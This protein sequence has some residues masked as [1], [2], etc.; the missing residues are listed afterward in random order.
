MKKR[1]SPLVIV[2]L[3]LDILVAL[4]IVGMLLYGFLR[5][6]QRE[7]QVIEIPPEVT[8]PVETP[9]PTP[10]P[11]PVPV[12][13][14]APQPID[15]YRNV[16]NT[17]ASAVAG[18][19]GAET[20]TEKGLNPMAAAGYGENAPNH[21]GYL[22]QDLDHDGVDEL[23]IGSLTGDMYVDQIVLDLYTIENGAVKKVFSSEE[24]DRYYLCTDGSVANE[25]SS[26]A[27][28]SYYAYYDYAAGELKLRE[29]IGFDMMSNRTDPWY[30]QAADG[31]QTAIS[32]GEAIALTNAVR[33]TYVSAAYQPFASYQVA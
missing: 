23:L 29:K 31:T 5:D 3:V 30:R 14:P 20:L 15:Y 21:I 16:L 6:R 2:L 4:A 22:L 28:D 17:Y 12:E 24:N 9:E 25:A 19:E 32:E 27:Y 7:V 1:K 10:E 11:T 26:S 33:D 18:R 13:T 8:A